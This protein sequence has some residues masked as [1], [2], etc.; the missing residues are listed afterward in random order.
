MEVGK[1]TLNDFNSPFSSQQTK[2]D[3]NKMKITVCKIK[4]T[5]IG[6]V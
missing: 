2:R 3:K 4:I 1:D 5:I 6:S